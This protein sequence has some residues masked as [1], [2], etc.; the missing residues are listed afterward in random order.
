MMKDEKREALE[1]VELIKQIV[2]RT[3]EDMFTYRSDL[4]CYI[5][6]IFWDFRRV[7][8][9]FYFYDLWYFYCYF[10]FMGKQ[11]RS[12]NESTSRRKSRRIN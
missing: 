3:N 9:R 4:I 5:W 8:R 6:G 7:I 11:R 10:S 12:K 2:S 1:T